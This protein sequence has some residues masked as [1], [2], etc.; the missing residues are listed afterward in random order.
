MLVL[1]AQHP[2]AGTAIPRQ[3]VHKAAQSEVLVTGWEALDGDA[4]TVT[5]QWPRAHSYYGAVNGRHD[6]LLLAETVRQTIPLLSHLGYDVPFGHRQIWD[7]LNWTADPAALTCAALPA[8]IEMHIQCSDVTRRGGWLAALRMDV[9]L[10]RDGVQLGT[11]ATRFASQSPNVYTRLRGSYADL[12]QAAARCVALAPPAP[13][14]RMGRERFQDVVLSPSATAHRFQ[15]RMDLNH[16]V[17]FDHPV[18]HAPGMLLLEAARQAAHEALYPHCALVTGM[19]SAFHRYV[20]FDAP[21]WIESEVLE[22]EGD[23][24]AVRVV[25]TQHGHEVFAATVTARLG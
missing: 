20:E 23:D 4:F 13:P 15:L 11:A 5:A 25:A 16:P 7:D 8:E 22:R 17:L 9:V 19:E 12:G 21:C 10:M 14:R 18:D 2:H 6:P 24:A 3:Y 1:T